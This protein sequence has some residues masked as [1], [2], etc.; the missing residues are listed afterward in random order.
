MATD[1]RS[2]APGSSP[3]KVRRRNQGKL[4]ADNYQKVSQ[5]GQHG[6]HRD[7]SNVLR[8]R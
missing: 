1:I 2:H 8:Q 5:G 7:V 4:C 3:N 6:R